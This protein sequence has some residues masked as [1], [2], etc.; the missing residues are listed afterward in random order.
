MQMLSFNFMLQKKNENKELDQA[1]LV[2]SL[3]S[4]LKVERFLSQHNFV[5]PECNRPFNL[6]RRVNTYFLQAL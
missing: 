6:S 4:S 1:P 3:Y 2:L 5:V